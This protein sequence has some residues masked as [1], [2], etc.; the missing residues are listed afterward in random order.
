MRTPLA[1][2]PANWLEE[3]EG[4]LREG[5]GT[6][7]IRRENSTEVRLAEREN[8]TRRQT[9]QDEILTTIS[10]SPPFVLMS[11]FCEPQGASRD[12][13]WGGEIALQ[14]VSS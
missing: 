9:G 11:A 5:E 10:G 6:L 1:D 12:Y 14:A 3:G 2:L 7:T 4:N 8:R 13:S